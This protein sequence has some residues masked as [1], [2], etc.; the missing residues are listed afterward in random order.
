MI[1]AKQ[2]SGYTIYKFKR[3][4][5]T[6]DAENDI[7]IKRETN[8][9][10][11]AWN[12]EDPVNDVWKPH[13]PNNRRIVVD[14]LLNFKDKNENMDQLIEESESGNKIEFSLKNVF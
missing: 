13:G 3:A 4:L 6:C 9:L 14:M 7:E 8:Y 11:F 10:I 5:K 12:D 1:D 2:V